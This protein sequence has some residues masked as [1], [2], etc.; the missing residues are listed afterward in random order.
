MFPWCFWTEAVGWNQKFTGSRANGETD[1]NE[2]NRAGQARSCPSLPANTKMTWLNLLGWLISEMKNWLSD[3]KGTVEGPGFDG[4]RTRHCNPKNSHEF[5]ATPT[6]RLS[7]SVSAL[8]DLISNWKT[9]TKASFHLILGRISTRNGWTGTC[10]AKLGIFSASWRHCSYQITKQLESQHWESCPIATNLTCCPN[11]P[12]RERC[13]PRRPRPPN[14]RLWA[15][16][17]R[18]LFQS[19]NWVQLT[20]KYVQKLL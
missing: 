20:L 7:R 18:S 14:P 9:L 2:R 16:L 6:P 5:V 19:L 3:W 17:P 1:M 4:T 10:V 13:W 11:G 15:N 8:R 12:P